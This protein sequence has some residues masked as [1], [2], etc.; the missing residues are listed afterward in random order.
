M[1]NALLLIF[2]SFAFLG[3]S[4]FD[5][6]KYVPPSTWK[7]LDKK[8][9]DSVASCLNSVK[10][11][12]LKGHTLY[13]NAVIRC[14]KVPEYIDINQADDIVSA[15]SGGAKYLLSA[16]D[17]NNW[18]TYLLTGDQDGE[19]YIM[20]YRIGIYKGLSFEFALGF[21][22]DRSN[23][24]AGAM[25]VLTL[26]SDL[27]VDEKISG[28]YCSPNEIKFFIDE[29]NSV[30]NSMEID[31]MKTFQAKIILVDPPTDAKYFRDT[32]LSH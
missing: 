1:K 19:Q 4:P 6:V 24:D 29:F 2:I 12:K 11:I 13:A 10:K 28:I 26:P 9:S 16:M 27:V 21:P 20:L 30:C 8:N 7:L 22:H 5:R 18:K 25:K 3:N 23:K 32:T 17:G 31:G 14:Y 15:H